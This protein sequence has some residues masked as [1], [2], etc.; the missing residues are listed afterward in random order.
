MDELRL[1]T[2][3]KKIF[4]DENNLETL[5]DRQF[6][7]IISIKIS[8]VKFKNTRFTTPRLK[9]LLSFTDQLN[10]KNKKLVKKL[11]IELI[12]KRLGFKI[13]SIK[14]DNAEFIFG[15]DLLELY[16]EI[17]LFIVMKDFCNIINYD[18]FSSI[19]D[20]NR[21]TNRS[22]E[23]IK[24]CL[25]PFFN[26]HQKTHLEDIIQVYRSN[27][28]ELDLKRFDTTYKK[29]LGKNLQ[30]VLENIELPNKLNIN[31]LKRQALMFF[32]IAIERGLTYQLL[33]PY[34]HPGYV[35]PALV[36]FVLRTRSVNNLKGKNLN[37]TSI[38]NYS[39]DF[40]KTLNLTKRT[41]KDIPINSIFRYLSKDI[42]KKIGVWIRSK[43][44]MEDFINEFIQIRE[45]LNYPDG[46]YPRGRELD[47]HGNYYKSFVRA[48]YRYVGGFDEVVKAAGF[49]PFKKR[50]LRYQDYELE[51]FANEIRIFAKD[52]G[53]ADGICPSWN[54]LE[55]NYPPFMYAFRSNDY[56]LS[57]LIPY[58]LTPADEKIASEIGNLVHYIFEY[59]FLKYLINQNEEIK[60]FY[61]IYPNIY[62]GDYGRVDNAIINNHAFRHNI[63]KN[64]KVINLS[65]RQIKIIKLLLFDYT[66]SS[67][68]NYIEDK[69]NKFYQ[70]RHRYLIIIS[71]FRKAYKLSNKLNIPYRNNI[72]YLNFDQFCDLMSFPIKLQ[73]YLEDILSLAKKIIYN[74]GKD[75]NYL[76]KLYRISSNARTNMILRYKPSSNQE[77]LE[78]EL[79]T[80][81]NDPY[82]FKSILSEPNPLFDRINFKSIKKFK[83]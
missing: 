26:R 75:K 15:R 55:R 80:I 69:C 35:A 66:L 25:L 37:A 19:K 61:E 40:L 33:L 16:R 4:Q 17:N 7:K 2:T 58:G 71:L 77:A 11:I 54:D 82:E 60:S 46:E 14:N 52:L 50:H 23:K 29:T 70:S 43:Y 57:D 8:D 24:E 38:A 72:I 83:Y 53:Y 30:F 65:A 3:L 39:S 67:D 59:E 62:S 44:N 73:E 81:I 5:S 47:A 10:N 32:K 68:R 49:D 6:S 20:D 41:C 1:L 64:Q 34:A 45:E 13:A 78:R 21:I 9:K 56:I 12:R 22:L 42:Q 36:Y 28:R 31:D 79:S 63:L 76:E 18:F 74:E 48:T 51:D 27:R